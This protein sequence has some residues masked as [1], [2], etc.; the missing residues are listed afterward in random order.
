MKPGQ[1]HSNHG[2][3]L[4]EVIITIVIVAIAGAML[5]SYFSPSITQS[6]APIFRLKAAAKLNN[7]LE[8]ISAH[9]GEYQE[10]RPNTAYVTGSI[11]IP[12][13]KTRTGVIYQASSGGT[14]DSSNSIPNWLQ[15][16]V[17]DNSVT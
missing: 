15:A 11:V 13:A 8:Q 3:T 2:F 6:S 9:Y 12:P 16:T 14:S 10:W 5:V 7:V 17:S 4:I 1:N